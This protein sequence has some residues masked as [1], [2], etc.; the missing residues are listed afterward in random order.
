MK[1]LLKMKGSKLLHFRMTLKPYLFDFLKSS[2]D[3]KLLGSVESHIKITRT[4]LG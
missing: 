3:S 2:P 1:K 4:K